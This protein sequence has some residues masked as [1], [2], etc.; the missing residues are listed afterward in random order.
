MKNL[1]I[2]LITLLCLSNH[3]QAQWWKG[4]ETIEGN[5]N[6]TTSSRSVSEYD[7]IGLTGSMDVELIPGSEGDLEI[8]AEENLVDYIITD[9]EDGVLDIRVKEGYNIEPSQDQPVKVIVPF[10]DLD[11]VRLTGSGDIY[12]TAKITSQNFETE[13]T[14]SGD[15]RLPLSA[16]NARASITGSGDIELSGNATDFSCKV[17][18]SGDID[19]FDF[20]CERVK[21]TVI[22]SGDIKVYAT[23]ELKANIPGSGD[24]VYKGNPK[25]QDFKTL[26]AG[27]ISKY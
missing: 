14:G 21:A 8:V 16:S 19:A 9:S 25:K 1:V 11:A 7:A 13:V 10:E 12:S 18:G 27:S 23:Q 26:G 4:G 17:T 3:A 6:L 15:I 20:K 22:G 5:G 24:I 2:S